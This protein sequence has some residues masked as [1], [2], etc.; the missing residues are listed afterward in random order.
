[1]FEEKKEDSRRTLEKKQKQLDDINKIMDEELAPNLEK[2]RKERDEYDRWASIRSEVDR[3]QR[4]VVAFDFKETDRIL[5]DG[6][7]LAREAKEKKVKIEKSITETDEKIDQKKIQIKELTQKKEGDEKGEYNNLEKKI[8]KINK[9]IT[10]YQAL[11]KQN[12]G[13]ISRLERKKNTAQKLV[14]SSE[15]SRLSKEEELRKAKS[16]DNDDNQKLAEAQQ[17]ISRIEGRINDV[18]IGIA[19]E[20]K[21]KSISDEIED[22]KK[23]IRDCEVELKRIENNGPYL[24]GR[25]QELAR[26]IQD[27]ENEMSELNE[28]VN[29]GVL[30]LE[31]IN[32][33]LSSLNFDPNYEVQLRHQ[34]D[35]LIQDLSTKKDLLYNL[36]RTLGGLEFK[37]TAPRDL[38]KEDV[39]GVLVKLFN[40][41]DKQYH[42]ALQTAAGGKLYYVVVENENVSSNLIYNGRLDRKYSFIPN[43]K[44]DGKMLPKHIIDAVKKVANGR[45]ANLAIDLIDFDSHFENAMKFTFGTTI[46]CDDGKTASDIAYNK[47]TLV[48]VVTKQGDVYDPQGVITGGYRA[49]SNPE[50]T[51]IYKIAQYAQCKRDIDSIQNRLAEINNQLRNMAND[52]ETFQRLVNARDIATHKLQSAEERKANSTHEEARLTLNQVNQEIEQNKVKENECHQRRKEAQS[53]IKELNNEL[54]NWN[55]QKDQKLKSLEKELKLAQKEFDKLK[56]AKNEHESLLEQ[57]Q[58]DLQSIS[59]E[60]ENAQNEIESFSASIEKA[61]ESKAECEKK[62]DSLQSEANVVQEAFEELKQSILKTKDAL[63]K[64]IQE[65]N[66]LQKELTNLKITLSQI[67]NEI[68]SCEKSHE[69]SKAKLQQMKN[70]FPWIEQEER[71]FGVPHTDF[72]FKQ[73]KPQEAR[74]KL[75]DLR[76]QQA[77]LD[78]RVNKRVISQY[79]RAENEFNTLVE[80]KKQVEKEKSKIEEVMNELEHKKRE[81]IVSTHQKVTTDLQDIVSQV[82]P[83]LK[84]ELV[85]PEGESVFDGLELIVAFNNLQK[86]LTELS[87]GQRSLIALG[88]VLALLKFK[89][90][91]VYILDE[92]DSALDLNHTQNIGKMLRRSFQKA[93]FIVVS[94][95]EGMWN[96]A[97]VVFRTSFR[98]SNS[99]VQRTENTP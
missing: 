38:N 16:V 12:D 69:T 23:L 85:P 44:I 90:A 35:D 47:S 26:Q 57:L 67:E 99:C 29:N 1:M 86:S 31:S 78:A 24:H 42:L 4:W 82:L 52:S 97:N 61:K 88:L 74:D 28:A 30:E 39:H 8:A 81:A 25:R 32:K 56:N 71:F 87:G 73:F 11:V 51:V 64:F 76:E 49:N 70:D 89:P 84:A 34:Q 40:A 66:E 15:V 50:D 10:K 83:G 6:I 80:K 2:L 75:E 48:K 63:A 7:K 18:N 92:I 54:T 17:N 36:E 43:N 53:K 65:E 33:E 96:N 72:D 93:Q 68:V 60:I 45:E 41:P 79:D 19:G 62:V 27:A 59:S 37:Y 58:L 20:G 21:D 46:I 22:Q 14:E 55:D 95:K 94:L 9:E 5:K 77:E 98:D 3:M 13:E 91:P